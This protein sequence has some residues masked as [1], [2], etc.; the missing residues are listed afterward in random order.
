M[1]N[2]KRVFKGPGLNPINKKYQNSD[3]ILIFLKISSD[4]Q[5]VF[6]SKYSDRNFQKYVQPAA[7]KYFV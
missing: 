2:V 5:I 4:F 1:K 3:K 6:L 7:P